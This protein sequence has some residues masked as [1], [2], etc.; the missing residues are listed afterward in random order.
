MGGGGGS[1]SLVSG[2][3]NPRNSARQATDSTR[4]LA[5]DRPLRI[6]PAPT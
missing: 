5:R 2:I 4:S 1:L 3:T 6:L